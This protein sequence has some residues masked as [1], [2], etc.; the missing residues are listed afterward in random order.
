MANISFTL[1]TTTGFTTAATAI[2]NW[3]TGSTLTVW[4]DAAGVDIANGETVYEDNDQNPD[5]A[6]GALSTPFVGNTTDFFA[7]EKAD[8]TIAAVRIDAAG[9]VST[10][11]TTTTTS[12]T[13]TTTTAAP[14]PTYT[15]TV[16]DSNGSIPSP[17]NFNEGD[18]INI[19]IDSGG[20]QGNELLA[21]F[22]G[23]A[24]EADF[25]VWPIGTGNVTETLDFTSTDTITLSFTLSN[26][27]TVSEG[28]ETFIVTLGA[29]DNNGN[30]AGGVETIGI[31]DTSINQPPVATN[32]TSTVTQNGTGNDNVDIDLSANVNDPENDSMT[33]VI[34]SLPANGEL[35]D[36]SL[37]NTPL[38]NGDL[39]KTLSSYQAKYK[40]GTTFQGNASFTW[41][42][43]DV[44]SNNSNTATQTITVNAPANQAPT[45]QAQG[46]TFAAG[47]SGIQKFFSRSAGDEDTTTLTFDWVTAQNGNTTQTLAQLNTSLN[48]GQVSQTNGENY[49]YTSSTVLT[50]GDTTVTDTFYFKA[51]DS[52]GLSAV[53]QIQYQLTEPGN[54]SPYFNITPPP[55]AIEI[56]Q[57]S[58]WQ[59]PAI[60]AT[61]GEGHAVTISILSQTGPISSATF[62]NGTLSVTGNAAGSIAIV[63]RATDEYGSFSSSNDITY[64]FTVTEV[65]WRAVR[66]GP[67]SNSDTSVC[68]LDRPI[69]S[70]YYYDTGTGGSTTLSTLAVGDFLYETSSLLDPV[71]PTSTSNT[72]ISVEETSNSNV[73]VK[74]LKLN[75]ST[76]AIEEVLS[77]NVTGGNAWP[78]IVRYSSNGNTYCDGIY[79]EG[80]AWQNISETAT[81]A[82]VV[83]AGGQLFASEY[84]AN[85]YL[86]NNAPSNYVLADGAYRQDGLNPPMGTNTYYYQNGNLWST[87]TDANGASTNLYTCPEEITYTTKA[88]SVYWYNPDPTNVGAVCNAKNGM[89]WLNSQ[90]NFT[91]ITLYYRQDVDA[92]DPYTLLDLAKG[93]EKVWVG[94]T[95][96]N[97]LNYQEL[98]PS[99]VLLDPATGGMV[100]WDNDNYTGYT[101]SY[102]WYGFSPN[103][104]LLEIA[105]ATSVLGGCDDGG[106]NINVDYDRPALW[107]IPSAGGSIRLGD[108]TGLNTSIYYAF[109]G[110]EAQLDPGI[111]GGVPYYPVYIIDGMA[112]KVNMLDPDISYINDFVREITG[113]STDTRSQVKIG[114]KCYTYTNSIMATNISDAVNIMQSAIEAEEVTSGISD[115]PAKPVSINAVDLGLGSQASVNYKDISVAGTDV[116]CYD[117]ITQAGPVGTWTTY[118]FPA[119]DNAEILNRTEPNFDL[120]ENYELENVSKPLLRTNPKLSTNVKLVAN[121]VDKIYLESIN[122]TKELA[123]VEYKKWELN[124][125]GDYAYDLYKFYKSSSTPSDIMYA[126]RSDYSDYA[127]QDSFD[128][129]IEEVY[130]YGT[131]Y[132]YSKL[133]EEGLRILA[134]IWLD[135][136]IPKKFVIFR[137]NDPVGELD[138]DTITNYDNIQDILKN[139]EIVKTFDLTS[140]SSLGKYIRRHVNA[141]AFPK[142]PI[143]FN[144]AREEKSS[145]RGIDL[146]KGG[147]ASKGEFL[148][149]DFI[150]TDNPLIASNALI[151]DGFERNKLASANLINLEFLF[152]DNANDYTINRYF[153]LYVNDIDSGY[154]NV[155]SSIDG[156]VT[157]K[158]LVSYINESP[159]SAIPSFKHIS[160]TPTLGYINISDS[161]YKISSKAKY[162]TKELNLIVEDSSNAIPGEIRTAPNGNSIDLVKED[163]AGV[164]FVK[165]TI[166]STPAIN[167]RFVVFESRESSYS[168]KFLR[169]IP[170]EV[171]QLVCNKGGV[172][173]TAQVSTQ[174]T[175][176]LTFLVIQNLFSNDFNINVDI[177][178][179]NNQIFITEINSTLQD[180]ELNFTPVNILT[181]S[182]IA[183]VTQIQSSVNLDNSTFFATHD[184]SAGTFNSTS[185]SL[186]GT[187][188]EIAKAIAGCINNSPINFDVLIE[189][190]AAE[191]YIKSKLK[192]YRL[193]QSGVLVPGTNAEQFITLENRDTK[194]TLHPNGLLKLSAGTLS[195]NAVYYMSGGNS[196]GKSVLVTKDSASDVV[197]GNMIETSSLNTYNTVIDIVDDT[198]RSNSIYKK[199]ILDNTNT[200]ESGEH[201]VYAENIARLGLFS[202]Y[203]IHD[204]NFD[205]YDR[206]NSDLKELDYET[207]AGI[208]YEPERSTTNT[209]SVFGNDYDLSPDNYFSGISDILPEETLDEYNEVKLWSEYDR[210][211]EN[212]LKEFAIK[213]RVVPNINKWVLKDSLTV[214]EQPYYLNANEAFGRTNFSPDFGSDGRDR[215]GM[216]HEWF[217]MD[218]LPKYL[219]HDQL[220]DTFSY[221]NFLD[222][223]ELTPAHFKSTT[224]NYFDRFMISEGFEINGVSNIQSYIKTN[225]KK[226]YTPVSGGNDIS[227][228]STIFKGIK[229]N[230]KNRKE[231]VNP[232]AVEFV[233]SSDFN[234]YKF[235]TLVMVRGGNSTNGI[236][237]EVIQ[238]KKFKFVIFLITVSLD[239]LWID[240]ALN[241][242]LLYELNHSFV[243]NHEEEDFSYSDINLTGALN[244]NDINFTDPGAE[245]YL[246]ANGVN[247][248]SGS[249]P[250][251]L[252]Q[253]SPDED[254]IFGQLQITVTDSS[255]QVTF[256]LKIKS[257]DDQNQITLASGPVDLS[258]NPVN[259]SNI[260]GY[261]QNSAEY[262]YKQGG[263]N[264]FTA[265]MDRLTV[266]NVADLLRLN[267]GEIVYTTIEETGEVLNNRFEISFESGVEIIK[268]SNLVTVSDQDKPKTFKLKQGTIGYNLAPGDTYYPFLVRHN[269]NYTVDTTPVVTFTDTY[270][271]FKTNT[272]QTTLN[273]TELAFEES[274]YKHSLTNAEEIKLARDYYKRYNRCNT[275]FNLGFIQDDGTHDSNWGVIKNHFYRKVNESN[276]SGVT[277]LSASTDK[278]PL[279]P[280]IGEVA[281]DKK[282]INV[283]KS[284]WDKNYYTR[285]LSGGLTEAI[286]GTF[287]TKEERSYLGS[288]IMKVRDSY[289]MTNFTTYVVNS[290]EQQ[291]SILEN[292]INKTDIVLFEDKKYV[293]IDFYIAT[294][295]KRVLSQDG[296][297]DSIN[298]FVT[299]ANSAGDKTTTSDDALLY[300][301]NNLLNTFNLDLIKIYTS[302]IKGEASEVLSSASISNLDDGGFT[303]DTNFTFKAHEQKPL[304]F[305]LIYNKRLGYSYRI[306]PMIKIQS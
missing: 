37:P 243:W 248:V 48:H 58:G 80:E 298:K 211:E 256:A 259:V 226:K 171:W 196:A 90:S 202:A 78:L 148:Y 69:T 246:V 270:S 282:D 146:D 44:N 165:G 303:N 22:S 254:N 300:V 70:V 215:L 206:S 36:Q 179:D 1:N 137:V 278:L 229:V 59:S 224:Y 190:G 266:N 95:A 5:A 257:I 26:D 86:Q 279:Y 261:V 189:D 293:Y 62:S 280:L 230:F 45:V 29:T 19:T 79:E 208:N 166:N 60:T 30:T 132:N 242:K 199:I 239:D 267:D 112:N 9:L 203:D 96:A 81:L 23:T 192:G 88:I 191:F 138:F 235:S 40:P 244:L 281:I 57:G 152:D 147:F 39:P 110:C 228:A 14:I 263:K 286:P 28:V 123:S 133:H 167:D 178:K 233:K 32:G 106:G 6:G 187:N 145:F 107:N 126:T 177:D 269:G 33:W 65:P 249:I 121:S 162:D 198:S 174:V 34:L 4:A 295:I 35:F 12:S 183:K 214:R 42:A 161:F 175:M 210:L 16:K 245:D 273:Q 194:T 170:G 55:L 53:G 21:T 98:Q 185:F 27:I 221:V 301:E 94:M 299:A 163:S 217:Y 287:E 156:H 99:A 234:G 47:T 17:M 240:G 241:R 172:E 169:H 46:D 97:T 103:D 76:G 294:T 302:R 182:S 136:D 87:T 173:F 139:S 83:S 84:Y 164:D 181:S 153:G 223:F 104:N 306:R 283:F 195:L 141:E 31:I 232:K 265:I 207:S 75:A 105:T 120:E 186:Q 150:R 73:V 205:F 260:A 184:L 85:Q 155:N 143:Q 201:K 304:N 114:S 71:V 264:A 24:T 116:A 247:H 297:L 117:C 285:S 135:K 209:L 253:I 2:A 61:D 18:V 222:G 52:D 13:T 271:H 15:I 225:L 218:N 275:A 100:V 274:M 220:N 213:S 290:Q 252:D 49:V 41:K 134:P 289:N 118:T 20:V 231:F 82:D 10:L 50:P 56:Q 216:T 8:A 115:I 291:D 140:D 227:F 111:P 66:F 130:H 63:L 237:Y 77:C 51:T 277:K 176:E 72:W 219:Q 296:V 89:T 142:S 251:F 124:P 113:I 305:R 3:G 7:F 238:N 131:T 64:T 197:V 67:W 160:G 288:T 159:E 262:V 258:G 272:L 38:V 292:N 74:A 43:V 149:K 144:F 250:Q 91:L 102:R 188:A 122:A 108:D 158:N 154:G 157:L 127:V 92:A 128:K 119:I 54:T 11:T 151:T 236:E 180:L 125:N 93:Q 168:I 25:T 109:Y 200:L 276:A 68:G 268:Q 255:G 284:S 129:Q 101:G 193:L 204:M 212:S